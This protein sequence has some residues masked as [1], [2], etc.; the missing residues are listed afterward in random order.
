MT[1][2]ESVHLEMRGIV[3]DFAGVRAL[4]GVDLELRG[5]E[6]LALVGENGAGK[7]TLINI[8]GGRWPTGSYEGE[9]LID[10]QPI[11]FGSPHDAL[12]AGVAVIHQELQLIPDLSVAENL[13]LGR[14]P[15]RNGIVN[16]RAM[17]AAAGEVLDRY[18]FDLDPA[19][20]LGSLSIARR[21]LV[22]IARALDRR[23]RILVLDEPSSALTEVETD[24]M[25]EILRE[26]RAEGVA[27]IYISHK[28]DEVYAVADRVTVLRDGRT[29]TTMSREEAT[30]GKVVQA[31]VGRELGD[32]YQR[33]D[34][35]AGDVRLEVR[36]LVVPPR[37][38]P[39]RRWVDGVS[40]EVRGGEVV[41]LAGLL[42][43]GRTES[44]LAI[45]GALPRDGEVVVNGTALPA[46]SIERAIDARVG[47]V[48]EDRKE[49]GLILE[50]AARTNIGL[51]N[52]DTIAS[53]GIVNRRRERELA[54]R[55]AG[56]LA[57]RP[58]KVD[59]PARAFSGGNQQ[60]IVIAKWLA[61]EPDVLLL[62][63][64][65]RGVDV[66][67][68]AEIFGIID[69]LKMRGVAVLMV[70]SDLLEVI[71][72]ADRIL[73]LHEGVL[74][75]ELPGRGASQE[76]IMELATRATESL[77]AIKEAT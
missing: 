60:K 56:E 54:E 20:R 3:K 1:T 14:L 52:L 74:E 36:G 35:P 10:G 5:G 39:G 24:R 66:G 50:F 43:S 57:L 41:A 16:Q 12:E 69:Q 7:S 64:P 30:P 11:A 9:M 37:A 68:K 63:E 72:V 26:L 42:G 51:A 28:L 61:R 58:P 46:G 59:R 18:G 6:I 71:G 25:L 67:A 65:T 33:A 48:T 19:A 75:G 47:L 40:F 49:S 8:I 45:F 2:G 13:F 62:D 27:I 29:V 77:P 17:R 76:A 55:L 23:A 38:K 73:V 53:N 4:D 21:Q 70:S 34:R 22:E 44:L 32:L 31:M 15:A